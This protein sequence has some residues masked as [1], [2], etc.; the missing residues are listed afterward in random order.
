MTS[1]E[2]GTQ[3]APD[4]RPATL[5]RTAVRAEMESARLDFHQLINGAIP[6]N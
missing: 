1:E 6:V 2:T 4:T 5:N 3:P